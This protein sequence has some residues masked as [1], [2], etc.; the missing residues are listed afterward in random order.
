MGREVGRKWRWGEGGEVRGKVETWGREELGGGG[1]VEGG[2]EVGECG[3]VEGKVGRWWV[4]VLEQKE[5]SQDRETKWGLVLFGNR[6]G[7]WRAAKTW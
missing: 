2:G 7:S 1:E 3:K 4:V 6:R 5:I